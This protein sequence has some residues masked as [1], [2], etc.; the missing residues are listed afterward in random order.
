MVNICLLTPPIGIPGCKVMGVN[1]LIVGCNMWGPTTWFQKGCSFTS[2]MLRRLMIDRHVN[3]DIIAANACVL[4]ALIFRKSTWSDKDVRERGGMPAANEQRTDFSEVGGSSVVQRN[5][6]LREIGDE[7]R[8]NYKRDNQCPW[9][10]VEICIK[11]STESVWTRK[12]D[13]TGAYL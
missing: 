12:R 8:R 6:I 10:V 3:A 7:A 5:M 9:L 4:N 2:V 1:V 11:M 13:A